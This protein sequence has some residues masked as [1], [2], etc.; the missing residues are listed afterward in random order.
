MD[1]LVEGSPRIDDL[2]RDLM[3]TPDEAAAMV[4]LKALGWGIRRIA[5]EFGCSHETVRRYV[6]AGGWVEYRAPRRTGRWTGVRRLWRS[7]SG[8]IA[9]TPTWCGRTWRASS[10]W[11]C[12]CARS[13]GRWRV[14]ARRCG[15][16]LGPACG[17]RR[18]RA[19]SFR[20]TSARRGFRSAAR[21]VRVFLFVA[22]LGYSRRIFV[23]AFRHERQSAW[24]DGLEAAFGHFGGVPQEVSDRQ[25]SGAGRRARRG[26]ARGPVQ[27]AAAARSPATGASGREPARRIGRAPR[28]RTSAAS[29]T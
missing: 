22:T 6:K 3:R 25:R 8:A 14:F 9:A 5:T 23:Q 21:A 2:R 18:R 27:R 16:R 11:S 12:R 29:A 4:R 1:G 19:G 24:F 17:S 26:D 7:G 15:R 13:S 28:A 20:S 10:A